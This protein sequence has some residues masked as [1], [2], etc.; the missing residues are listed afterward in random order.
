MSMLF[1]VGE[2][3]ELRDEHDCFFV[4]GF[5]EALILSFPVLELFILDFLDLHFFWVE[6]ALLEI[7]LLDVVSI[8]G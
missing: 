4:T 1:I 8:F 2:S 6:S 7:L 3:L 5:D